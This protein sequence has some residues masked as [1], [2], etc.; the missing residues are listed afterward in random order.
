MT[1]PPNIGMCSFELVYKLIDWLIG[2][3]LNWNVF[4]NLISAS[5]S[6]HS[7]PIANH[8]LKHQQTWSLN[9]KRIHLFMGRDITEFQASTFHTTFGFHQLISLNINRMV[10]FPLSIFLLLDFSRKLRQLIWVWQYGC[11]FIAL[12][13]KC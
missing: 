12:H 9:S 13:S 8:T 7:L 11:L 4:L 5:S 10:S 2:V 6:F 3:T 1:A